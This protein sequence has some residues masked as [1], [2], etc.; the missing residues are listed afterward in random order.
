[1][2][3]INYTEEDK[4][5]VR[6]K[7]I[8]STANLATVAS[9]TGVN[10]ATVARWKRE[11]KEKGDDWDL[12]RTSYAMVGGEVE[13]VARQILISAMRLVATEIEKLEK[14]EELA[15]D[16]KLQLFTNTASYYYKTVLASEKLIPK[17][18]QLAFALE[19]LSLLTEFIA[20]HDKQLLEPFTAVLEPFSEAL[21]DRF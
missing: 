6:K 10:Y 9:V 8:Y 15:P 7:Y 16:E 20:E 14:V 5:Q 12:L 21:K 17:T 11:S 1:M 3:I 2:T 18:N 19:I 4:Q 13:E